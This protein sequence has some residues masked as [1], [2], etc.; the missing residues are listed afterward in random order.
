MKKTLTD[1]HRVKSKEFKPLS[2][3]SRRIFSRILNL[4]NSFWNFFNLELVKVNKTS[5]EKWELGLDWPAQAETMVGLRRLDN[6]RKAIETV[7]KEDIPGD[8]IETGVW[9]GGCVIWMQ[10]I[11]KAQNK[12]RRLF[13][14]D[15]F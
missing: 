10:A 14:V 7:I 8:F 13:L 1:Y 15:S 5:K 11:L 4:T 3:S 2:N 9:R 12:S 6:I